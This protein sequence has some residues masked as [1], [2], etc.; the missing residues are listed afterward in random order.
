ME[1]TIDIIMDTVSLIGSLKCIYD[2]FNDDQ[3]ISPG[4]LEKLESEI[5]KPLKLKKGWSY[6]NY[7]LS[8][9]IHDKYKKVLQADGYLIESQ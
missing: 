3:L 6:I 7:F 5:V 8:N 4:S 1:M 2:T 9:G